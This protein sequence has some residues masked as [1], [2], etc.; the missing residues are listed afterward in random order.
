MA[1]MAALLP[2]LALAYVPAPI[3][4]LVAESRSAEPHMSMWNDPEWQ[5]GSA[6]GTAHEEALRLRASLTT[7]E[8]RSKFLTDVGMMDRA[9]FDDSKVVLA[10]KIQRA[11]KRCYAEAYGLDK[12]EQLAWR[13]LMNDMAACRFEGYRGDL[14]LA[15]SIM[16][17]SGLIE[18]HRL[19]AL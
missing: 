13:E 15:E 2:A 17:R 6:K 4:P 16:E 11:A 5:W 9:D 8:Q 19:A 14:L 18:G 12:E 3:A 7:P 10:L 1:V